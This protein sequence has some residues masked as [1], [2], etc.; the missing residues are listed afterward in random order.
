MNKN[1]IFSI[2]EMKSE[3]EEKHK[4]EKKSEVEEKQTNAKFFTKKFIP[5]DMNILRLNDRE[6]NIINEFKFKRNNAEKS[7]Q[8][9]R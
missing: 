9:K 7:I 8:T 4:L 5:H 3:V 1:D 6:I 2:L